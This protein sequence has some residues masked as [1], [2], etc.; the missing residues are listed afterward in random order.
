[1][2]LLSGNVSSS[3]RTAHIL[4]DTNVALHYKMHEVDWR[5]LARAGK[6]IIV[7]APVFIRELEEQKINNKSHKI[8]DRAKKNLKWLE[9]KLDSKGNNSIR[10]GVCL[11][12]IDTEPKI[13]FERYN[14]DR[15]IADDHLIASALDY[16]SQPDV[17]PPVF[18][19]TGD[20]GLKMKVKAREGIKILTLPDKLQLKS[21]PDAR[22]VENAKLRQR[23]E[24]L[25]SRVPKL[26]VA[27]EGKK[28]HEEFYF[29]RPTMENVL[30]L[31]QIKEK[32]PIRAVNTEK[33]LPEPRNTFARLN[34]QFKSNTYYN[35]KVTEYY[36]RYEKY[37]AH[38]VAYEEES[39]LCFSFQLVISND[40]TAP[41]SSIDLYLTLPE[42]V[43]AV[44]KFPEKPKSPSPPG[45]YR[46]NFSPRDWNFHNYAQG[47]NGKPITEDDGSSVRISVDKLKHSSS[48]TCD[49]ITLRFQDWQSLTS[50]SMEF[51]I[52][53]NEIPEATEGTLHVIAKNQNP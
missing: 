24:L 48:R 10:D 17:M 38:M 1:V 18:I 32:Y 34:A 42:G 40:G 2:Q 13:D 14:L 26:A 30:S 15:H 51:S 8:R 22:E 50:F 11:R 25:E 3:N 19:A 20:L 12:F 37:Y 21:E 7:I 6:V 53:A 16:A 35:E 4:V 39:S 5:H 36:Q 47:Y 43:L 27:F 33:K 29:A 9:K 28:N 49:Y 44:D 23:V 45:E 46:D 52:S 31:S 41:A